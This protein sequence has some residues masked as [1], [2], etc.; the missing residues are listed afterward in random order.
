MKIGDK[1]NRWTIL[2]ERFKKSPDSCT[3]FVKCKCD[4]GTIKDVRTGRLTSPSSPSISCGCYRKEQTTKKNTKALPIGEKFNRLVVLEDLGIIGRR[5]MCLAQCD[6][7]VVKKF[8]WDG[9]FSGE[10]KSC[11]CYHRDAV[12]LSSTTHGMSNTRTHDIW[13]TMKQRCINPNSS[14]YD[15]YGE[16]G[17]TVCERWLDSFENFYEDM[18]ECPEGMS[19]DRIDVNR[20]YSPHNCRWADGTT[21]MHNQNKRKGNCTSI[22][23]GVSFNTA[24]N[25]WDSRLQKGG[26]TAFRGRFA[27]EIEA[28]IAYDEASFEHYGD[29]PNQKLIEE[30]LNKENTNASISYSGEL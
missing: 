22:F 29:R 1:Y 12:S 19:I 7:G 23:K 27:S 24:K 30:I 26:K 3:W 28:A 14:G 13:I 21:Q 10:T 25:K 8:R 18:G 17:I 6:C 15:L 5:R 4:C 9:V 20:G 11:G 16:R 2:S